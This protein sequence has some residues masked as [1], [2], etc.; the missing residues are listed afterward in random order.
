MNRPLSKKPDRSGKRPSS[1]RRLFVPTLLCLALFPASFALAEKSGGQDNIP[2]PNDYGNTAS[3]T[4]NNV[5]V[6]GETISGSVFG[7]YT[8]DNPAA[9]SGNNVTVTDSNIEKSVYG[10]YADVRKS[11]I[12]P[13]SIDGFSEP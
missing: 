8:T 7:A 1:L 6:T 9:V 4:G 11:E 3:L 10:G 12:N 5:R 13:V 2:R